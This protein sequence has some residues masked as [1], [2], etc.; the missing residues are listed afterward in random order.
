VQRGEHWKVVHHL[1]ICFETLFLLNGRH[2]AFF[3]LSP[4]HATGTKGLS[5]LVLG[6]ADEMNEMTH[7][8]EIGVQVK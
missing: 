5:L 6:E 1:T 2:L 8:C 7:Y 3:I 4:L